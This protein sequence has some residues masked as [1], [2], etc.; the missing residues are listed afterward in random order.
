MCAKLNI[1]IAVTADE[2][3]F[4]NGVVER[5]DKILAEAI[6]ETLDDIPTACIDMCRHCKTTSPHDHDKPY[7]T[8]H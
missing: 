8:T 6:Q 3:R 7:I 4:S 1:E 5:H 2:S